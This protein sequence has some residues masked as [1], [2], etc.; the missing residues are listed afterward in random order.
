MLSNWTLYLG[1]P[2]E[3]LWSDEQCPNIG[4]G[5]KT[6]K[7]HD[8]EDKCLGTPTCTAIHFSPK[9]PKDCV[10]RACPK[11][12]PKP[13]WKHKNYKGYTVIRYPGYNTR[14]LTK[15]PFD[16][17]WTTKQCPHIGVGTTDENLQHCKHACHLNPR[18]NAVT[19]SSKDCGLRA[20]PWP[21]PKP[22]L[23]LKG[24]KGYST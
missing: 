7:L 24:Y 2:F 14:P 23:E 1:G 4:Q 17:I 6:G 12:V 15:G 9:S 11:P 3:K 18:C 16:K 22:T 13:T 20:C 19:F 5:P 10:L 21:I 8:C